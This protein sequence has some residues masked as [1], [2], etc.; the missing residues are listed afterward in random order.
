MK[1]PRSAALLAAALLLAAP[2]ARAL[3]APRKVVDYDIRV[4]LDPEKKQLEGSETLKWTNP[5]DVPVADLKFHLYWNAFRNNRSTFMKESGG[6]LRTDDADL[7]D[8]W[9]S[10]D[11]TSMTWEGQD[12]K[13]GSRFESPDD[14]NPDDRTVLSVPLPRPVAPGET[15]ALE[16]GWKARAPKVCARAG[17]VRD[18]CFIGQWFPKIGVLEPKGMRRRA[19]AGWNCHQYHAMSEF[20]A[21]WGDY[22][23]A[24][25]VPERFVVGSAGSK[26][27][28]TRSGGKKTLTFVQNAIHD[29][30]W[31]ADPRYVVKDSLFDP[32]RDVPASEVE[33]ASKALGIPPAEL[34]TGLRPV[35]L[36]FYMQPDHLNQWKRYEDAQKWA[37]AWFGLWCFPYPYAQVSIIDPP[38]DGMGAAGMEYQ[39]LYTA[40]TTRRLGRWPF[41]GFR[42]A[43][44]VVI[45]EFGHGYFY[46]LL[47]SNEFEESWMDEGITSFAE[48]VMLDRRYRYLLELP[49]GVG[50]SDESYQR[51]IVAAPD[52]DP[53]VRAA[54]QYSTSGS[55]A[56]NSYPRA[57]EV[58]EELR[59]LAGEEG[60]WR[61]FRRY[62]E[63]WRFD[64]PTTEDFLDEMR[65]LGVPGF[66]RLVAK[67]FFGTGDVDFRVISATSVRRD[68]FTGYDDA[69][70][71]VNFEPGRKPKTPPKKDGRPYESTVVVG[72]A[73][74][75][76]LPV[77]VLLRFENGASHRTTWD[78]TTKW[79]RLRTTYVSRL[80]QVVLDPDGRVVFDR[81]PFNNVKSVGRVKSPSASTKVRAYAMHLVEILLS[82]FWSLP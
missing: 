33:R 21:D 60:F 32:A 71:S 38:E 16:I 67:T 19:E 58:L 55:Y 41:R 36:L 24:I 59:R 45:H 30:A 6:R 57:A 28:E 43:E 15:I 11:V 23:V 62:A 47:A 27:A 46:G 70:K 35:K 82:A 68:D 2:A 12:L 61:A 79:L 14:G 20:Y 44:G 25:T 3:E 17:Y 40:G 72:R 5:A 8:G 65:T 69:G 51:T 56:R 10:I 74:D 31:T 29:F 54:W 37:L 64:H 39:T 53:I 13:K 34:T 80:S 75:L 18:F 48:A 77:D 81:D 76:A 26:V 52:F 22:R 73:G 66:E 78:G 63:R 49:F 9:G 50:I 1:G 4:S 7:A 42:E